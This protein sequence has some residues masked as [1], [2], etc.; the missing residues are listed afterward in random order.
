[1]H[2]TFSKE[3][4]AFR[5]EVR[6]FVAERFDEDLRHKM[7][8]TKNGYLDKAGQVKWQ[9]ALADRGWAAV[10]WPKEYGGPGFTSNQKYLF[11]VEMAA[12]GTPVVSPMGIKMVAPVL[13]KYGSDAQ[14]KRFLPKI[15]AAEELWCQE[16]G[17]ASCR[18][19][20]CHNV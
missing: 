3:D 9:K 6:A 2:L 14:K 7:A 4:E 10:N 5:S 15:A 17:R 18:E 13:M 16:I 11:D 8:C 12:A 19:R 1:M 20:V